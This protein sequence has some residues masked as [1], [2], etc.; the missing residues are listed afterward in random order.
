MPIKQ[1]KISLIRETTLCKTPVKVI[2]H[3]F[4]EFDIPHIPYIPLFWLKRLAIRPLFSQKWW[5]ID[6]SS[7]R[8]RDWDYFIFFLLGHSPYEN[9]DSVLIPTKMRYALD[10]T[11]DNNAQT[12]V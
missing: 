9:P 12:C 2:P 8:F 7:A 6:E 1:C 10:L 3:L 4:S 5:L 11:R